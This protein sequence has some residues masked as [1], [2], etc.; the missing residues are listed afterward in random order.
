MAELKDQI[1]GTCQSNALVVIAIWFKFI[2]HKGHDMTGHL[3]IVGFLY[4]CQC[5]LPAGSRC[6]RDVQYKLTSSVRTSRLL[7]PLFGASLHTNIKKKEFNSLHPFS[8]FIQT[9]IFFK[10]LEGYLTHSRETSV[11]YFFDNMETKH[12]FD[13]YYY[14][15]CCWINNNNT[16]FKKRILQFVP[17]RVPL[18]VLSRT[19]QETLLEK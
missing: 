2:V 10:R 11:Y 4:L 9:N 1:N 16:R 17:L 3:F 8:F 5:R 18:T 19:R 7:S 13:C 6:W 14:C 15:C 12:Y